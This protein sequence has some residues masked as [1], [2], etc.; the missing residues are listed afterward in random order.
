MK[1][2]A[3]T[4]SA[5]ALIAIALFMVAVIF[6]FSIS[7]DTQE[8]QSA[9]N[10][11]SESS[12]LVSSLSGA[13]NSSDSFLTGSKVNERK[14]DELSELDYGSLKDAFGI[15]ADFCIHFEDDEGNVLNVSGNKTGLGNSFVVVGGVSCG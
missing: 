3:Q 11:Q 5:D 12:K 6:F 14:I 7:S 4:I 8:E 9:K 1:H 2:N 15:G 13:K 10:L